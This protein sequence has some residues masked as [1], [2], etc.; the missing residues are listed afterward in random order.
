ME[1]P[2][3]LKVALSVMGDGLDQKSERQIALYSL[4]YRGTGGPSLSLGFGRVAGGGEAT[5]A[6]E[7]TFSISPT[8]LLSVSTRLVSFEAFQIR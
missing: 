1:G 6:A 7:L 3:E 4:A 8:V 5:V 2:G